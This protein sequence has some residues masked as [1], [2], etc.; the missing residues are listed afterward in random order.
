M[1]KTSTEKAYDGRWAASC[2]CGWIATGWIT[3]SDAEAVTG[4]HLADVLDG[5]DQ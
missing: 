2:S 1:H 3:Q 5:D 4:E